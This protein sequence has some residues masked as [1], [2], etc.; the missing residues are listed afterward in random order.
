MT[1]PGVPV[2]P[3]G[4]VSREKKIDRKETMIPT[5]WVRSGN[6]VEPVT[7]GIP[8]SDFQR[9][10]AEDLGAP[11]SQGGPVLVM[12]SEEPPP[13]LTAW[14]TRQ[15]V[16]GSRVYLLVSPFWGTDSVSR[17]LCNLRSARIMVRR[18]PGLPCS[19]IF[20]ATGGDT[21]WPGPT[22]ST[23]GGWRLRLD[24]AQSDALRQL[25]L[26]LFWHHAH[27]EAWTTGKGPWVFR[28]LKERPFD[29]PPLPETSP[30]RLL[31]PFALD[32]RNLPGE[33]QFVPGDGLPASAPKQLFV[34][35]SGSLHPELS[36]LASK[37]TSVSWI[38]LDL[39]RAGWGP[40]GAVLE[41]ATSQWIVQIQLNAG[42]LLALSKTVSGQPEW[43]FRQSSN[44]A[45]IAGAEV[46]L[47]T[48]QQPR[49]PMIEQPLLLPD[50]PCS[51]IR[52]CVTS[53]PANW[54]PPDPLA[55]VVSYK[56]K[57]MPPVLPTGAQADPL[58][59]DWERA[60][61]QWRKVI[62]QLHA[63]LSEGESVL[64]KMQQSLSKW[65]GGNLLGFGQ[66]KQQL[67]EGLE[68]C[69]QLKPST[70]S[71]KELVAATDKVKDLASRIEKLAGDLSKSQREGEERQQREQWEAERNRDKQQLD[72]AKAKSEEARQNEG[73]LAEK[74][75][76][77]DKTP[78][79]GRDGDWKPRRQKTH[80]ELLK[81][82]STL[83]GLESQVSSLEKKLDEPFVFKP[84]DST[85]K[86]GAAPKGNKFVPQSP[87][88][89]SLTMPTF[90]SEEL[91]SV[92]KLFVHQKQRFL[93][94]ADWEELEAGEREATRLKAKLVAK[95]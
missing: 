79:N 24:S 18:T 9:S 70:T 53:E 47:P 67:A 27:D 92:G 39:P 5:A 16:T 49:K 15:V 56:W 43:S 77:L 38:P 46:W 57:N 86:P 85:T 32:L 42:Q 23:G 87:N 13:S 33:I 71:R 6:Q 90:P 82:R 89:S 11:K 81:A 62:E 14:L 26:R 2:G 45:A 84:V 25:F 83:R 63:K 76:E 64:G 29:V 80:D 52:E 69:R 58:V 10:G 95:E 17:E 66:S 34:P 20:G 31:E 7:Q 60:D 37:G 8:T 93:T 74:L 73:G 1:T 22:R 91:P 48:E 94:I 59:A 19:A 54:S 50:V 12:L 68:Q 44:L 65:L 28:A 72:E 35:P 41:P 88:E 40:G 4:P 36:A 61:A 30:L 75:A 51:S 21:I 55:M 78:E 3:V